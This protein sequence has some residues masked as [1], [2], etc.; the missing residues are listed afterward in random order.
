MYRWFIDEGISESEIATR[1]NDKGIRTDLDRNWTRATVREVLTNEKYV[2]NNVYNR[3]SFKLKQHR[4]INQPDM[5]IKKAGAFEALISPEVFYMA[6]GIIRAR[7]HRFSNDELIEKLRHL[8][9]H[10]GFLSGLIIDEA[11][12]MPSSA[13]YIHRFGSLIR[14]Y[15]AVGFTPDRDYKFLEVNRFLRTLHPEIIHRTEHEIASLGGVVERDSATDLLRINEE[16]SVSIVLARCQTQDN[17]RHR[18]KIR[19][20]ASLLPDITVGVRLD[21]A[22]REALDYYLLP[23]LDF[24]IPR[25]NLAEHNG[26]EFESYRFEN[27]DYL[28]GMAER[29]HVRRAM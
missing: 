4:I 15:Q 18:W 22:N 11:E 6:Q 1:L 9:Q 19:F 7:N 29:T 28:H 26:I 24:G 25:I 23:R 10:R 3:I 16:F 2:G 13:A 12:D 17:G 14:A 27:L 5:W 21:Q 20:D 8:F